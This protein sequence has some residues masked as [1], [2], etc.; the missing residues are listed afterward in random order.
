MDYPVNFIYRGK[1]QQNPPSELPGWFLT[2]LCFLPTVPILKSDDIGTEK[3]DKVNSI[4]LKKVNSRHAGIKSKI[5][6][7]K[8]RTWM[9]FHRKRGI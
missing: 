7:K 5:Y 1:M 8:E 3:Q 6:Q 2:V 9:L 4:F